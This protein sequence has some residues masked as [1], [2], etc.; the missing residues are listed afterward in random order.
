[1]WNGQQSDANIFCFLKYPSL[2]IDTDGTGTFIQESKCWPVN[3]GEMSD[4]RSLYALLVVKYSGHSHPLLLSTWK[5]I[6]PIPLNIPATFPL[7][8]VL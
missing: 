5:D 2:H 4:V 7:H 6:L 8:Y 1:M 3:S